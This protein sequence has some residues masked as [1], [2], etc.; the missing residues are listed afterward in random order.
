MARSKHPVRA[1]SADRSINLGEQAYQRIR[2][3]ILFYR[4]PPGSRVSEALLTARFN[5]RQAAVRSA[6]VRLVQEGLVDKTDERSPRVAA[7]TLK[8]VRDIYGLRML[9]EPRAAELAAGAGVA[10]RDLARLR[11]ISQSRYELTSHDELVA[12]LR[13]NREFNLLIASYSGN[14]RLAAAITQL[15]DLTLRVLYVGIRSLNVSEWFQTT[16]T[17]IVDAVEAGDGAR[18]AQLWSTDLKYG[19]R[20]ISDA[21][22]TLPELSGVNLG[23]ASLGT[24]YAAPPRR[25]ARRA[26]S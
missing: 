5:L 20:L 4:L 21:L 9:L 16:H 19:E 1:R 10:P 23:G 2:S 6:L 24:T 18:A 7:L 11:Q 12:F 26:I 17:Q 3:E 13:A 22:V 25:V 15:Q 8:D 14:A